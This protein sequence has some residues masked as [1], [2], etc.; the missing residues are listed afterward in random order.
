MTATAPKPHDVLLVGSVPLASAEDVFTAASDILGDRLKRIPDGETGA[1]K[2]W[3]GWQAGVFA[4]NPSLERVPDDQLEYAGLA[5]FRLRPGVKPEDIRFDNLGYADAAKGSWATFRQLKEAGK[6]ALATKFQVS[7]PTPL[8]PLVGFIELDAQAAIEPAYE[9]QLLAELDDIC[10]AIPH[11]QLA[12]QWDIAIEMAVWE[13]VWQAWFPNPREGVIERIVRISGRVPGD[14]DLGYHLCYGD[15][16][17]RHFVQPKD[18][19]NLVTVANLLAERV[20]RPIAWLHMPVPRERSDDAYFAPL[21]GLKLHP[22]TELYLGL[23]HLSDGAAGTEARIAAAR[24]FAPVFGVATECG[25]GRRPAETVAP[26][27]HVHADVT[28]P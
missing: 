20:T 23:V 6:I 7:L 3:I 18:T 9:R 19:A 25:F 10:A 14:V 16:G 12:V 8:A 17:H 21:A 24:R 13:G 11:D 5:R 2:D 4:G 26:L 1:R 22:E 28:T 15:A 27:L